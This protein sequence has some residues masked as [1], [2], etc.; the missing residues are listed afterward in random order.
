MIFLNLFVNNFLTLLL[1][2][3]NALDIFNMVDFSNVLNI[4][5]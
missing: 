4:T 3:M 5:K 2:Q 1:R